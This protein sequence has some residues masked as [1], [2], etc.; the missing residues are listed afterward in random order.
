[1]TFAMFILQRRYCVSSS[2]A[3]QEQ[4]FFFV[5][6][7]HFTK[8]VVICMPLMPSGCSCCSG[9]HIG[10]TFLAITGDTSGSLW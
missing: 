9:Y 3:D 2:L 7:V 5:S 6:F 8:N 4:L 10:S 1:M